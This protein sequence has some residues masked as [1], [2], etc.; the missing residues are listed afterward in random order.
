LVLLHSSSKA[1]PAFPQLAELLKALAL[2]G[3]AIVIVTAREARWAE[4]TERWLDQNDVGRVELITRQDPGYRPDAV[5]E[6]EVR[7]ELQ[8]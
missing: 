6:G 5:V 3:Y 2:S 8:S 4:F 1:G 7:A